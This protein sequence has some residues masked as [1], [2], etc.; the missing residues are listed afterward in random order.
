[1][2]AGPRPLAGEAVVLGLRH[3]AAEKLEAR[4]FFKRPDLFAVFNV[5]D[6]K[7]LSG[8]SK[9]KMSDHCFE[10]LKCIEWKTIFFGR[11]L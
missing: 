8:S 1:M 6:K 11:A 10:Y 5:G 4:M 9:L 3:F 2:V 7:L